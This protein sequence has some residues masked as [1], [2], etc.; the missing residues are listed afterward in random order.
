M[1]R[2]N[3]GKGKVFQLSSEK[4]SEIEA[5][6]EQAEKDIAELKEIRVNFRWDKEHLAVVKRAAEVIGVPYQVYIKDSLFRHAVEDIERN[7]KH[8]RKRI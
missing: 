4:D 6:T 7:E 3:L 8:L 5:M 2:L 1:G